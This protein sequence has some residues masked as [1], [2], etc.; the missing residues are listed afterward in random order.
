MDLQQLRQDFLARLGELE[1]RV[2]EFEGDLRQPLD[3]DFAEQAIQMEGSEVTLAL[4]HTAIREAEL[5]KAA[6]GRID[7][8]TYGDCTRCG[9]EI[10][11]GRLDAMP[12]AAECVDC[13]SKS[14]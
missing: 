10:S 7:A 4:E 12:Y 2:E 11:S 6:I 9:N 1:H 5:I 13:A 14:S 3:A 8:G